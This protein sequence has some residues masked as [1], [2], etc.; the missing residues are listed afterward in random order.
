MKT[1]VAKLEESNAAKSA[2]DHDVTLT[3]KHEKNLKTLLGVF[4]LEMVKIVLTPY[5]QKEV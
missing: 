5:F 3:V 4:Q 1:V 2:E